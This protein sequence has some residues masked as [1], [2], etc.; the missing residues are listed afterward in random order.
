MAVTIVQGE[1]RVINFQV[2]EVDSNGVT[3]YL[4]LS[5]T[6]YDIEVKMAGTAATVS[7]KKSAGEVVVV[8]GKAGLFK[9]TMSDGKTDDLKLGSNQNVEVIIDLTAAPLTGRKKN[10]TTSK[11]NY[12]C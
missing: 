2:K 7:F 8:D 1:D 12:G 3:T 6:V 10:S 9:V 4:D 5:G 11:S